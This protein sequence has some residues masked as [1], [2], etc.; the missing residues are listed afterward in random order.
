M[1]EQET[2]SQQKQGLLKA[3]LRQKMIE[4]WAD[5]SNEILSRCHIAVKILKYKSHSGLYRMFRPEEI[6]EIEREALDLRRKRFALA[7]MRVDDGLLRRAAE[8]DPQ[9]AKLAYMKFENWMP[10]ERR[11]VDLTS[12]VK[13][14]VFRELLEEIADANRGFEDLGFEKAD[15]E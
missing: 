10:G 15:E 5:P 13:I 11:Q 8:G 9:A 4:Y 1:L 7:L 3:R 12:D 6:D 2:R 14:A